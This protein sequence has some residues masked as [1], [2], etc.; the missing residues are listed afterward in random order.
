MSYFIDNARLAEIDFKKCMGSL[1]IA[2]LAFAAIIIFV[3][4]GKELTAAGRATLAVLVWAVIIW[5]TDAVPK[6]VSG[7]AIPLLLVLTGALKKIPEAFAGYTSNEAFLVLGAFLFAAVIQQVGLDRRIAL[8]MAARATSKASGL[9]KAF[10]SAHIA[11]ALIIPATIARAATYFPLIKGMNALFPAGE[12]GA[13]ARKALSMAGIG[14]GAT[15]AAPLFLTAHMPNVIMATLFNTKF[16]AGFTW[17]KWF[18]LHWPLI[19]LMPLVYGWMTWQFRLGR[20]EVPGG[21]EELVEM[22]EAL[23][24]MSRAE[25]SVLACFGV[26]VLLWATEPIHHIQTGPVTLIAVLLLFTPGLTPV[27]WRKAQE[28]TIWGTWLMLVGAL[29]LAAAVGKTGLDKWV[30]ATVFGSFPHWHWIPL[31]LVVTIIVQILRL[32]ICAN[33]AAVALMAPMLVAIGPKLGLNPIAFTLAVANV[34]TY[35]FLL[36]YEVAACL[37]AYGSEEFT[38]LEFFKAGAPITLLALLYM[39][40]VMVPWWALNGYPIWVP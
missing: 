32:G 9:L 18:W 13:R 16:N 39:T 2:W 3:P 30:A 36:P 17:F 10:F 5:L 22:K 1:I 23:G 19:G 35:A 4:T 25:G 15:L 7:L 31:L 27:S 8:T 24:P 11:S 6:G 12:E 14:F 28:K 34:D 29:S 33:V 40:F 26:A 38:F 21:K 20:I 37:I